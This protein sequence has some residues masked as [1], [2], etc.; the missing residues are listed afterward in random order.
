[1]TGTQKMGSKKIQVK[2]LHQK[3]MV[4]DQ[5]MGNKNSRKENGILK[6]RKKMETK[7]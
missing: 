1:M 3:K 5:K 2:N 6:K 7:N 4:W